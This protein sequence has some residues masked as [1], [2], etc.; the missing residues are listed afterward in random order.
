[1]TRDIFRSFLIE[2]LAKIAAAAPH[3]RFTLLYD[4]ARIH[5]GDISDVIFSVG[6]EA[7]ALPPWS[8]ELNP[9]EY[10]FPTWKFNYRV[11]CKYPAT[12]EAIAPAIRE[13]AA[14]ITPAK[15]QHYF[16]HT[17]SLYDAC[18]ALEDL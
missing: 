5:K 15:C 2:L 8:P 11:N 13:S 12:E 17:Q 6:H 9:I 18:E 14:L 4:N 10:A 7:Q 3:R 16:D 1:M